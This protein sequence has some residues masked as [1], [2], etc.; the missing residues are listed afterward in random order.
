MFL[1]A[2]GKVYDRCK[3]QCQSIWNAEETATKP[4]KAIRILVNKDL[5][6]VGAVMAAKRCSVVTKAVL[7][8]FK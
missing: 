5:K 2:L 1:A 4:C 7:L 8:K 6:Q 3:C